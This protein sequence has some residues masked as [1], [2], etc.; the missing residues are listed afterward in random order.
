MLESQLELFLAT[1]KILL[2]SRRSPEESQKKQGAALSAALAKVMVQHLNELT[3]GHNATLLYAYHTV[4]IGLLTLLLFDG[5]L[6][7]LR[8][9]RI[10][11]I[12]FARARIAALPSGAAS[13]V[14]P[15]RW[16]RCCPELMQEIHGRN[17]AD[18]RA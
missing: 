16:D 6:L 8:E 2:Y 12:C 14:L 13:A 7:G 3:E 4:M 9:V 1:A 15:S 5:T 11:L 17:H 18:L 10:G